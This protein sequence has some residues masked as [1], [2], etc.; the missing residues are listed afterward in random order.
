[1]TFQAQISRRA[2]LKTSAAV[3]GG[4][5]ISFSVPSVSRRALAADA[6]KP[7]PLAAWVRIQPD[8]TVTLVVPGSE[9]GQGIDTALPML[10]AEELEADW[11][12]V[13]MSFAEANPI[14]IN[15]GFG[16][17]ATGGSATV[18]SFS[19]PLRRVGATARTMLVEAAAQ[20]WGVPASQ[21]EAENSTVLHRASGRKATYGSL[22]SAAAQVPQPAA[23]TL[24]KP[25]QWKLL[26]KPVK[27]LDTHL[28]A[29]G[30]AQFGI[31]AKVPGLLVG[32]L[33]A[34]PT[35]GG[36]LKHVDDKPALAKR[37]VRAVVPLTGVPFLDDA[38]V[39]VADGY[40]NALQGLRALD[41]Q[42]EPGAN[43]AVNDATLWEGYRAGL[44]EAGAPVESQG[45]AAG[46]IAGAAKQVEAVYEF[47]YLAHA[48]MEPMNAT[49]HVRPD[50]ADIWAPTQSPGLVQ[51]F[52]AQA[53]HMKP[54]QV[55]VNVTFLGGGFG[56]RFELDH[57]FRA[58]F[59][60]KAVGAPVK[61]LWSREEDM[62]HDFYRPATAIWMNG[63]LDSAGKVTGVQI[64]SVNSSIL[65][66][67]F[68]QM[69]K[70][71]VDQLGQEGLA[72]SPYG[73]PARQVNYLMKN[74]SIPVGFWR[75]VANTY[76]GF[77]MES[78]MDE[79]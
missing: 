44:K 73:F 53:L 21:C 37:G 66:R 52:V 20:Q 48:T 28:K 50:G 31:D 24:K 64:K 72:R 67:V 74:T 61:V 68:P 39:V 6:P 51:N 77:A 36:K 15:P 4:L 8:N 35:F 70:D 29:T 45:D 34:S 30:Q 2:F 63:G 1:M 57:V 18:R 33:M 59:A 26:G 5:L 47:P 41:I 62:R 46:A 71:G 27:R 75:S 38:V 55:N 78:Y 9:M 19:E 13:H 25:A 22:A 60:S 11:K 54:E 76:S 56:R 3:G 42:W 12:T 79:L 69:V 58:V 10:L 40:W 32:T 17:Q 7:N 65:S 14:Y 16:F 23:V 43:G 49:A